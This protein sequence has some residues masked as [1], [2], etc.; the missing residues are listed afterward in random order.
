MSRRSKVSVRG[1]LASN[2][3]MVVRHPVLVI[4]AWLV[5]AGSLFAALPPLMEVAQRNPP[6]FIPSD[7][8]V[9]IAGQQMTEAFDQGD[10]SGEDLGNLVAVVL[11]NENGL[12]DEDEATYRQLVKNLRADALRS[13]AC[14]ASLTSPS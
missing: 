3:K 14:R 9:V 7:S 6:D 12:T 13:R 2:G 8:A 4:A 10:D 1:L 5:I 11:I